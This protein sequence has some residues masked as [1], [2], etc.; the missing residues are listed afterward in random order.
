MVSE[1]GRRREGDSGQAS[2]R[3]VH[4]RSCGLYVRVCALDV[5]GAAR[6]TLD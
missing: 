6:R 3:V 5:P 1:L 2:E 4:L